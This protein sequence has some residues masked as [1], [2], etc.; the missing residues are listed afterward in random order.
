MGMTL[1]F[2][3]PSVIVLNVVFGIWLCVG[4]GADVIIKQKLECFTVNCITLTL[5]NVR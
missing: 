3:T 2:T 1:N 5:C 4:E